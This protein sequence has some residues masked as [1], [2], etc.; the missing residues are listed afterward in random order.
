M[1][2]N[3]VN[4]TIDGVAGIWLPED[5]GN[6]EYISTHFRY[7]EFDCNHCGKHGE[8][9]SMELVNDVLEDVRTHFGGKAVVV[10]SGVRCD[11]HNRAVGGASNSRH[12][13]IHADAADIVV[14]DVAPSVVWKYL[15]DNYPN[16]YGIGRYNS[17]T[18]IDVRPGGPARW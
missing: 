13:T 1:N 10:N 18:H 16:K 3:P 15:S 9:I 7:S 12:R 11:A 8:L 17:F 5:S 2:K 6:P 14:V 4:I